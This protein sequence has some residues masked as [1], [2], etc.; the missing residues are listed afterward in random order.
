MAPAMMVGLAIGA[1]LGGLVAGLVLSRDEPPPAKSPGASPDP[2][3]EGADPAAVREALDRLRAELR[4]DAAPAA[5]WAEELER[6]RGTAASLAAARPEDP[7]ATSLLAA[8]LDLAGDSPGAEA[9]WREAIE[10]DPARPAYRFAL[11]RHLFERAISISV[12]CQLAE[13]AA[14][15]PEV[16]RT[17]EA[18][19]REIERAFALEPEAPESLE[20]DLAAIRLAALRGDKATRDELLARARASA[21]DRDGAEEVHLLAALL[22][23]GKEGL[24][25]LDASLAVCPRLPLAL[26][27]RAATRWRDQAGVPARADLDLLLELQPHVADHWTLRARLQDELGDPAAA[28]RDYDR[29]AALAPDSPWIPFRRGVARVFEDPRAAIADLSASIR[30]DPGRSE[31]WRQRAQARRNMKEFEGAIHDLDVA[32]RL[33]PEARDPRAERGQVRFIQGANQAAVEDFDEVIRFD[34]DDY[35]SLG[36]RGIARKRLGDRAGAVVLD[37]ALAVAPPTW[38]IRPEIEKMLAEMR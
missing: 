32:I 1:T 10:L 38:S 33:S 28:A 20:R 12:L 23:R 8:L 9:A 5:S 16:N 25:S 36:F 6:V 22:V 7:D 30:L 34:P 35:S 24:P 18:A 4:A 26:A 11:G 31:T 37:V 17:F 15:L 19:R 3:P 21:S 2:A 13:R 27:I 14:R 29:A